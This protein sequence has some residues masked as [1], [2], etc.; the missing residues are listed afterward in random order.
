[1][2]FFAQNDWVR[3]DFSSYGS[4]DGILS[5]F[6][7]IELNTAY[8]IRKNFRLKMRYFMVDQLISYG[9]SKETGNRI[10]LDLYI[11]F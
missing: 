10:R 3:W 2:D 8:L 4:P 9:L 11:G 6:K 5:K 1:M 7:G